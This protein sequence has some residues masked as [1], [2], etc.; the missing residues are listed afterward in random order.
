MT[1]F[2]SGAEI[3]R[4]GHGVLERT[5]PKREWTHAAHFAVAFWLLGRSD[6]DA[7]RDMRGLIRAYN[8]ASGVANTDTTGYHE[9][10]TVASLRAARAWLTGI[11]ICRCMNR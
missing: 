3:D 8:E 2:T 6:S 9:T 11:R 5:L 1:Q 7:M 10:I 4:I